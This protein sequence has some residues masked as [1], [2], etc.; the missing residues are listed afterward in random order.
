MAVRGAAHAGHRGGVA[1][2]RPGR[3][4]ETVGVD[5]T[6]NTS[7]VVTYIGSRIRAFSVRVTP[8]AFLLGQIAPP[9]PESR[10]PHLAV[11]IV[12]A[13]HA[14]VAAE[15]ALLRPA[16]AVTVSRAQPALAGGR[17]AAA[18][19]DGGVTVAI[20]LALYA[21]AVLTGYEWVAVGGLGTR[22]DADPGGAARVRANIRVARVAKA[23]ILDAN[24]S[25]LYRSGVSPGPARV[26]TYRRAALAAATARPC[27]RASHC[28]TKQHVPCGHLSPHLPSRHHAIRET[29]T[30][31]AC[32]HFRRC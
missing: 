8:V 32:A 6:P 1:H 29:A 5:T 17:V 27:R 24:A 18:V 2:P 11:R 28:P 23:D 26:G 20:H 19:V 15:V 22:H 25:I 14:Q 13:L 3:G 30:A 7:V 4:A 16:L 31:E 10:C 21:P 9:R 12:G